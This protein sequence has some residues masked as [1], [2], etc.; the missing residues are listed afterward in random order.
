[1][2]CIASGYTA[3]DRAMMGIQADT[4]CHHKLCANR[5]NVVAAQN[6]KYFLHC[7]LDELCSHTLLLLHKHTRS[8]HTKL[9][10][11][12]FVLCTYAGQGTSAVLFDDKG[13]SISEKREAAQKRLRASLARRGIPFGAA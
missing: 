2:F 12:T 11:N 7:C 8:L 13:R 5:C 6:D 3:G 4:R 9:S 10:G 1:M